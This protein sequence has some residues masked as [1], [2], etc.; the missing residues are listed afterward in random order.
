MYEHR[1]Q[2]LLTRR[3]FFRRQLL[4]IAIAFAIIFGSLGMGTLGYKFTEGMGWL[5]AVLNASMILGG[6]GPVGDLH[7]RAGKVFASA[8]AL[9]S[10]IVF[11]VAVGVIIAPAFH[12]ILHKLH[13]DDGDDTT[14]EGEQAK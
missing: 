13:V 7:T 9:Y 12:R 3:Q 8:Y 4:H 5:D 6:M 10:G 11:L 2:P 1:T 14:V